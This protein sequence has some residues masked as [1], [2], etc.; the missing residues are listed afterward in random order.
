MQKGRKISAEEKEKI[1]RAI[2]EKYSQGNV[3]FES[4]CASES[5]VTNTFY[6]WIKAEEN[7]AKLYNKAQEDWIGHFKAKIRAV[8]ISS[9]EKRIQGYEYI[10]IE[11]EGVPDADGN[12]KVSKI[13]E[14]KKHLAPDPVLTRYAINNT[15]NPYFKD[16]VENEVVHSG[17][18]IVKKRLLDD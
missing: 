9:L 5:I 2:C 6:A 16:K 8:A 15:M 18:V 3:T 10:E 7:F 11:K 17:E 4:C 1:V 13:R 12:M 14:I